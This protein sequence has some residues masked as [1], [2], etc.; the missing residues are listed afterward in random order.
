MSLDGGD[1]SAGGAP[2]GSAGTT[3]IGSEFDGTPDIY[4][5]LVNGYTTAVGMSY[6]DSI[7]KRIELLQQALFVGGLY[8]TATA[9]STTTLTASELLDVANSYIGQIAVPLAGNMR[10][11]GRYISGYDG[12]SQL[13]VSPAWA[14]SPGNVA[15]IIVRSGLKTIL[16]NYTSTR[17]G[18]LDELAAANLPTDVTNV[19]TQTDK[20]A[21]TEAVG[22]YSYLDAG[23][24]QEIYEN[25]AVN[26]RKVYFEVSNRNMTQ[27][28]TFRVYRKVNGTNY[29]L[30][31]SQAVKVA[32][33]SERAWDAEFVTNQHWRITYEEDADE[34]TAR[35]IPLNV[36][37]E[38]ME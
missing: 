26:R 15:F 13:T 17:A 4:D 29:D 8:Y 10:G 21:G 3:A 31:V 1:L 12:S 16:D 30:W 38:M 33:S 34:G 9:A 6:Q 27:T 7:I 20:L 14:E 23:G 22:P 35:D 36:I 5:V 24:E 19:K 37:I 2:G 11:Q 28:G 18:Y 32:A 25:A